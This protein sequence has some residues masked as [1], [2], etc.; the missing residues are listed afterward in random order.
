MP[1][2]D[3]EIDR[4]M[5][6]CKTLLN[7]LHVVIAIMNG[8]M[9][10]IK[11]FYATLQGRTAVGERRYGESPAR[12]PPSFTEPFPVPPFVD[13]LIFDLVPIRVGARARNVL[14]KYT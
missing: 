8:F 4:Y 12:L 7:N 3:D 14:R 1:F 11:V 2:L 9:I 6:E 10:G 5:I 13:L